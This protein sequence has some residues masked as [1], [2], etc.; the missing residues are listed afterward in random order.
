MLIMMIAVDRRL[1]GERDIRYN[2]VDHDHNC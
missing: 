1:M 2:G